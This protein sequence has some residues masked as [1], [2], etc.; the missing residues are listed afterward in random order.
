MHTE[1]LKVAKAS[2]EPYPEDAV[3]DVWIKLIEIES[4]SGSID[5]LVDKNGR[6]K[7]AYIYKMVNNVLID[8]KRTERYHD[9]IEDVDI[10]TYVLIENDRHKYEE[11]LEIISRMNETDRNLILS[12]IQDVSTTERDLAREFGVSNSTIHRRL[13]KIKNKIRKRYYR[14]K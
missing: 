14:N 10:D 3:Q 12:Y 11:V 5:N 6:I 7:R 8:R 1:L 13:T 9:N 4:I 2:G